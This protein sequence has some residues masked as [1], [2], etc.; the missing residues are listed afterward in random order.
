LF[1]VVLFAVTTGNG[2]GLCFVVFHD[3]IGM[4][5]SI[6]VDGEGSLFSVYHGFSEKDDFLAWLWFGKR[7]CV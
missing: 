7:V 3:A 4:P 6:A 1:E 2:C 5:F